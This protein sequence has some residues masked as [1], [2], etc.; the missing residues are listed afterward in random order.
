[1]KISKFYI[2]FEEQL[3]KLLFNFKS[4]W[5]G[6]LDRVNNATHPIELSTAE[7]KSIHLAPCEPDPK[8]WGIRKHKIDQILF[9]EGMKLLHTK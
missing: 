8:E 1:M 5:G 3:F 7:A 4:M 6:Q 2:D 9:E